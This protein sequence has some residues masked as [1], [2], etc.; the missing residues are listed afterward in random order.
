MGEDESQG[1][2]IKKPVD[3]ERHRKA[4]PIPRLDE[5]P[6]RS[7]GRQYAA[8]LSDRQMGKITKHQLA[9]GLAKIEQSQ[10]P[11]KHKVWCY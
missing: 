5:K 3:K 10:L 7:L 2:K 11:G 8:D 6:L 1:G 9:E 4:Q